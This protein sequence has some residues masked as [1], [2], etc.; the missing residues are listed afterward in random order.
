MATWNEL[1]H[2]GDARDFF[3]R[4]PLPPFDPSTR[5][6]KSGN[7]HWLAELSRL[8]YRHDA[9]ETDSPT[10]PTQTLFLK[11]AGCT[12]RQFFFSRKT[13]TQAMLLEFGTVAPFAVL[14]FRGTELHIKDLVTDLTVGYLRNNDGKIDTHT[15]FTQALDS[16]WVDIERALKRLQCPLFFTGHSLGA[17]L[18]TLAAARIAPTAL[19]T[20]GSPRVGDEEFVASLDG[21]AESIHRVVYGEDIVA[22]VP[23][24]ALGFRH[25]GKLQTLEAPASRGWMDWLLGWMRPPKP[26]GDHAPVNYVDKT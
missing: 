7:A 6:Y 2:P 1:L 21:M 5:S 16:V 17:A 9:E 20:F 8:I 24:E 4:R 10:Q 12:R 11:K 26:F 22:T 14:V 3:S 23:P 19:Y 25:I 18:A 15:G 13:D